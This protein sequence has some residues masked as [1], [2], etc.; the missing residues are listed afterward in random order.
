MED[1]YNLD[2]SDE[3][4]GEEL[5]NMKIELEDLRDIKLKGSFVRSRIK[6]YIEGEKPNKNFLNLENYNSLYFKKY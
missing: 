3:R 6:E 5:Q 1:L 4:L 2:I